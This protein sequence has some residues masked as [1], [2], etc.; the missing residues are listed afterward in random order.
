MY[1]AL[2]SLGK[3]VAAYN[4]NNSEE[5]SCPLCGAKLVF[6][7]GKINIEHFAHKI[8]ECTDSWNYDISSWHY[9]MQIRFPEEQREVV[10]IKGIEKHRADILSG[11]KV[12][13]FQHSSISIEE[14]EKRNIFYNDAGYN[15]AWVFDVQEQYNSGQIS[16]IDSNNG[17]DLMYKWSNPKRSLQCFPIPKENNNKLMIFLYWIDEDGI[18][19]FNR[20]IWSSADDNI[21]NFKRFVAAK[22][23]IFKDNTSMKLDVEE[24]F[25]TNKDLLKKRLKEVNCRYMIK[26][27]GAKG[28][29]RDTYV[30][31]K[32][33]SFGIKYYGEEGCQYCKYCAAIKRKSKGFDSYCCYPIQVNEV[34]EIH[35]GYES[36]G[37]PEF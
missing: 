3:R 1:I 7:Q 37:I 21:P 4:A 24:F 28:Y 31:P 14:I 20:I 27:S 30:C 8:N 33:N 17:D 34:T 5:Y 25:L 29:K 23:S 22:H 15:V 13:E 18:E 2:N 11:S 12:I 32:T 19:S 35:P 6:K 16:M 26:H 9:S 36:I 10:V